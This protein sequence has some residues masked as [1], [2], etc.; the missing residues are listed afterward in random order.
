[1]NIKTLA[2]RLVYQNRWLRFYED[3]IERDDGS[4]GIYT[5]IDKPQAAL[6]IPIDGDE[7][8]LIEQFRYP[9][10]RRYMEFCAGA[11]EDDP[12]ADSTELARGELHE[13]TGLLAGKM[14]Y[15]GPLYY[16]YGITNQCFH[17]FR[18]TELTQAERDPEDTEID[19]TVHRIR[20]A[21]FEAM[22]LR[23][24]ILD[25]ASIAAWY[26]HLNKR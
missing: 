3:K 4:E 14:E 21:E 5:W 24:E 9:V 8:V 11:W 7:V 12:D 15:L 26:L 13:E 10:K 23:G 2:S 22:I 20:I 16:A 25:A 17:I 18:A 6:I 1:M 19:I